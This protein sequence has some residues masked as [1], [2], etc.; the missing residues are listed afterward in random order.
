MSADTLAAQLQSRASLRSAEARRYGRPILRGGCLLALCLL[1]SAC[2]TPG[3]RL[4]KAIDGGN[5]D[6][7][8][9]ILDKQF[10]A[11]CPAWALGEA[12]AAGHLE[13][14]QL[15]LDSGA[16]VDAAEKTA[17]MRAAETGQLEAVK[18]L[19]EQGAD[20]N[21][22]QDAEVFRGADRPRH[23]SATEFEFSLERLP[24]GGRSALTYAV[25]SEHATV[26]RYLLDEGATHDQREVY[27]DASIPGWEI[28]RQLG[29]PGMETYLN[30]GNGL[31]AKVRGS[32]TRAR[33][34]TNVPLPRQLEGTPRAI[35]EFTGNSEIVELFRDR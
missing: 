22:R 4:S 27:R 35:A 26:V 8:A 19:V 13:I 30:C 34:V 1:A 32:S 12:A 24:G 9:T 7:V 15:L 10:D 23:E 3:Q 6:R 33:V 20:I 5:L 17:L 21:R 14:M 25:L 29:H 28:A 18:W 11:K 31:Y 2:S 16:Q